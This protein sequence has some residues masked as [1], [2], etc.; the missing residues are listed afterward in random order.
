MLVLNKTLLP[1]GTVSAFGGSST[2]WNIAVG[3]GITRGYLILTI[4]TFASLTSKPTTLVVMEL[5]M[6]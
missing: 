4:H 5:Q 3:W 6:L 1:A 2:Q